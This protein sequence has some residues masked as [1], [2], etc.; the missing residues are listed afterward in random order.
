MNQRY[1]NVRKL[2]PR[3]LRFVLR[4]E[5]HSMQQSDDADRLL[6]KCQRCCSVEC[7]D[8][9][10]PDG[11]KTLRAL[12]MTKLMQLR[13][14]QGKANSPRPSWAR[15]IPDDY[16]LQDSHRELMEL[17]H[18]SMEHSNLSARKANRSPRKPASRD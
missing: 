18:S 17:F 12:A 8:A 5:T 11:L 3:T 1:E 4:C 2:L 9:E 6:R 15:V 10:D 16:T 13:L 7:N 14:H